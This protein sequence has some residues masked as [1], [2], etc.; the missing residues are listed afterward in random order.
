MTFY[1]VIDSVLQVKTEKFVHNITIARAVSNL[2][3]MSKTMKLAR[4]RVYSRND[5][6]DIGKR[7]RSKESRQEQEPFYYV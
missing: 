3:G 5:S 7:Y 6:F 4:L 1:E 2:F